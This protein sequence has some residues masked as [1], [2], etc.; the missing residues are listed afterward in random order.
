ML[1][2][3]TAFGGG[4]THSLI[5]LY[6]FFTSGEELADLFWIRTVLEETGVERIPAARVLTFVGTEADPQGP[7]PWGLFGQK[8]GKYELVKSHDERRQSPGKAKLRELLG[9]EPTLILIDEIAEFLCRLVEPQALA[10][11]FDPKKGGK[12]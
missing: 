11:A 4:K 3:E 9:E 2:L 12:K 8:L 6:H 1:H 10:G 5:A 7:T